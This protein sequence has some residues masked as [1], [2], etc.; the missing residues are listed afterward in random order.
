MKRRIL[1]ASFAVIII[2]VILLI[3]INIWIGRQNEEIKQLQ[4]EEAKQGIELM[5]QAP[6]ESPVFFSRPAITRIKPE[7]KKPIPAIERPMDEKRQ[8]T[9]TVPSQSTGPTR[10]ES[11]S[12][13]FSEE[14]PIPGITK[15]GKYPTEKEKQEMDAHGIIMY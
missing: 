10:I 9:S 2:I 11:E 1:Y 3:I 4:Q 15:I 13:D 6:I 5:P 7:L 8:A 14:P 12:D